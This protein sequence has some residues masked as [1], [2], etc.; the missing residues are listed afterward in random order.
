MNTRPVQVDA[1]LML[2][3]EDGTVLVAAA[4]V[5]GDFSKGDLAVIHDVRSGDNKPGRIA[6]IDERAGH[7][8]LAVD[9]EATRLE[10]FRAHNAYQE[11]VNDAMS[12]ARRAYD[13]GNRAQSNICLSHHLTDSEKTQLLHADYFA[14]PE[15]GHLLKQRS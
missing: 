7:V 9:D 5:H 1:D 8:G 4:N 3:A 14:C 10:R 6:W 2:R 15:C 11:L 12:A 13:T